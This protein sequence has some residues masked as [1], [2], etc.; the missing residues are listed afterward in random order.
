[1]NKIYLGNL[2]I[3]K[4]EHLVFWPLLPPTPLSPPLKSNNKKHKQQKPNKPASHQA[5]PNI[6]KPVSQR[7]SNQVNKGTGREAFRCSQ[8]THS[9]GGNFWA[10]LWILLP[11]R[12]PREAPGAASFQ[13]CNRYRDA[14]C[15]GRNSLRRAMRL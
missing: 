10:A 9:V 11:C 8:R 7:A 12:V 3:A 6:A 4:I 2:E 14:V 1:M 15:I 13:K 5:D